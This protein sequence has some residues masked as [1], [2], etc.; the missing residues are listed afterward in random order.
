MIA[1]GAKLL[2]PNYHAVILTIDCPGSRHDAIEQVGSCH[3]AVGRVDHAGPQSLRED[4][5]AV[6]V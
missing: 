2:K 6:S 4:P 5:A 1:A 3:I